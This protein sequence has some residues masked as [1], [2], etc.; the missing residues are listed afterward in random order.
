MCAREE[1]R[2]LKCDIS[3]S[4]KSSEWR[5]G[6]AG[7]GGGRKTKKNEGMHSER[8]SWDVIKGL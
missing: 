6:V 1:E 7:G 4:Q 2:E 5:C 3:C 8:K